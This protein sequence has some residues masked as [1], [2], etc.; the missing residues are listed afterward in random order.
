MSE[1][2][3]YPASD[4]R[5]QVRQITF[6]A[7][8][9]NSYELVHPD[10]LELPPFSAG[11]HIDFHFHDGSVRQY[12]LSN[13]PVE[14]HRYVI[15][16]L[17]E[18]DG[19]GGSQ[20]LHERVHVQRTVSVGKAP[21]N[22]FPL[23]DGADRHLLIAGGIGVTPLK[24][25]VHELE[26]AGADFTLHY[27][28]RSP[29]TTAFRDEFAPLVKEGRVVYHH[30]GGNPADGLDLA[31]LL[32][33]HDDGT[34]LYYCGPVGLMRACQGAAGHW[35]KGTVHF[36]YFT[37]AS[38]P[39]SSLS[40]EELDQAGDDALGLGFQVKIASSGAVY[41]VPNDKSIV[42]V[43]AEQGIH[44]ETSCESGLCAT[45]KVRYLEGE[46]DHRDM[47]MGDDEQAEYLTACC[48]R[49]KGPLLVLDL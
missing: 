21:R 42:Q 1:Q 15:A 48:S 38:S 27:C 3:R 5:L 35:P 45:C 29:A 36:E 14:R 9:I 10:G 16:V 24:S 26:R 23:A 2:A 41:T 32:E 30:D 47:V 37:A 33:T 20:A 13:D 19:R 34:H 4:M 44:V 11:A 49:S 46:V 12:S 28:T 25:M 40:G 6:Q 17:R 22:N 18:D 7:E 39:K 8:R 43:L 31:G